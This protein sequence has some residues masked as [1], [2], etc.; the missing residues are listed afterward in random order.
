MAESCL[1]CLQPLAKADSD[2]LHRKCLRA[3]YG[4]T[5]PP[6]IDL[7]PSSLHMFGQKMAGR[8]SIS[9][10]QRKVSLGWVKR[11]LRVA[12]SGSAYILKPEGSLPE[13]PANEHLTLQLAKLAG[14][15]TPPNGLVRLADD[16]IAFV[17]RRFDRDQKGARYPME[18]FC[19]LNGKYA[20]EKYDGTAEMCAD[21][22]RQF[23]DEPLVDLLRLF[24]QMLFSWWV[25]NG[26]LHL[27]NLSLLS[28]KGGPYQLSPAYDLVNTAIVIKDDPLALSLQ[29]KR[30]GVVR[31]DWVE[32]GTYCG[33]APKLVERE[34]AKL[35]ATLPDALP[36]VEGSFLCDEP[37]VLYEKVLQERTAVL[38]T[39]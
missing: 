5:K 23:A 24:R 13:L 38:D 9:G 2:G 25:G 19:Q 15:D 8:V 33:L 21:T 37:K 20:A 4:T 29:G 35:T 3:L 17:V 10:L 32:F 14:I 30:S 16:H 1:V 39:V 27:K 18:D 11:T 36:L 12:A 34:I 28:T 6:V 22:V 7:K 31:K 26:D